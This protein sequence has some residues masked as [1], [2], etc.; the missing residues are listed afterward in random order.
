M[1][2]R[3]HIIASLVAITSVAVFSAVGFRGVVLPI[4]GFVS[5]VLSVIGC[6]NSDKAELRKRVS[7]QFQKDVDAYLNSE[8]DSIL[9]ELE[10]ERSFRHNAEVARRVH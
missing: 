9:F 10:K 3:E 1:K 2:N 7:Q 4:I 5:L 8:Y 6:I